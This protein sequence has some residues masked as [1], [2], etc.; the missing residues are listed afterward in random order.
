[1]QLVCRTVTAQ[2]PCKIGLAEWITNVRLPDLGVKKVVLRNAVGL[3]FYSQFFHAV[4][5]RVRMHAESFS[6]A[7]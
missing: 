3:A 6:G 7:V 4:S 5:Q 2:K 1:M